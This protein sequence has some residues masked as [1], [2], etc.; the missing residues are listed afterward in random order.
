MYNVFV[1]VPGKFPV[2]FCYLHVPLL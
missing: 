2:V 1:K